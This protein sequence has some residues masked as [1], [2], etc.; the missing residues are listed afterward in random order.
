VKRTPLT[1]RTPLRAATQLITRQ[2]T[3]RATRRDE[4]PADVKV[5]VWVRA[6]GRCEVCEVDLV[7]GR[8]MFNYHHRAARGMGGSSSPD[9]HSPSNVLL[10]CGHGS[11]FDGCHRDIELNPSW[12][13]ERGY[14]VRH[15]YDPAEVAVRLHG[16]TWLLLP[17]GDMREVES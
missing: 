7:T 5:L 10:V 6:G 12:S 1:R 15:G 13:F 2:R 17:D 4:I 3:K 16:H 8:T 14:R 9:R 11:T